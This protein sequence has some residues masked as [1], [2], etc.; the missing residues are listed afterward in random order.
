MT[1]SQS[2][3]A[4]QVMEAARKPNVVPPF[5][6]S[7]IELIE[8]E[9]FARGSGLDQIA[10]MA[11]ELRALRAGYMELSKRVAVLQEF[12]KRHL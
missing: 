2:D 7:E 8:I 10:R 9:A 3:T 12:N 1:A 11:S 6:L 4:T 5:A